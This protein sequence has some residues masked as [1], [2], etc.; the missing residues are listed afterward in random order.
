[1]G[2]GPE[3]MAT[4]FVTISQRLLASPEWPGYL[5]FLRIGEFVGSAGTVKSG[6]EEFSFAG[7]I[8][9]KSQ[10]EEFRSPE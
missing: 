6:R 7:P 2:G 5:L 4:E 8:R 9:V 3:R 10:R 1:M